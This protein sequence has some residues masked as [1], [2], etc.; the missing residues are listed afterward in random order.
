MPISLTD[1]MRKTLLD[2]QGT[3]ETP[4]VATA[5]LEGVP[6]VAPKASIMVW[7]DDHLVFWERSHGKTLA[8]LGEN[9]NVCVLYFSPTKLEMLK[10]IGVAELLRDG[11]LRQQ[12][13][14]STYGPELDRDPERKGIAVVIRVDRVDRGST[15]LMSRD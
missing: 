5:S 15:V 3:A 12:I 1:E 6:D 13:M 9:P 10:F 7:D 2:T 11:E 8:N 4:T 14:E